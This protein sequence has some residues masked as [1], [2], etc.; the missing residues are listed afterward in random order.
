MQ[1]FW[2]RDFYC[3]FEL[4]GTISFFGE[5]A[6][7]HWEFTATLQAGCPPYDP[8][9]WIVFEAEFSPAS[10]GQL[11]FAARAIVD[12]QYALLEAET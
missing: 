3:E 11:A 7:P 1:S 9:A 5:P 10:P 6:D 4:V 2:Y 8:P 12:R